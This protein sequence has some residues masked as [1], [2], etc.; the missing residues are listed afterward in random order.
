[1]NLRFL[2]ICIILLT[3]PICGCT[4]QHFE[5]NYTHNASSN[6]TMIILKEDWQNLTVVESDSKEITITESF[7]MKVGSA[8]SHEQA[9]KSSDKYIRDY[10]RFVSN[11]T[12][13]KIYINLAS[14]VDRFETKD[15]DAHITVFLPKNTNYTIDYVDW[16]YKFP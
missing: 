11:E 9:A 12:N 1:M 6:V 4:T 8:L 5:R 3:I 7:Y 14:Y 2:I 10:V 16:D 13:L 15:A